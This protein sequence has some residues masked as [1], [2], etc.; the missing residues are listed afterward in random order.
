MIMIMMM[1]VTMMMIVIVIVMV[2]VM[3]IMMMI[4]TTIMITHYI[5]FIPH[6][7]H[8]YSIVLPARLRAH[9]SIDLD[10]LPHCQDHYSLLRSALHSAVRLLSVLLD[11][12]QGN[13]IQPLRRVLPSTLS[14][15]SIYYLP[16]VYFPP[17]LSMPYDEDDIV[18][19]FLYFYNYLDLSGV[20]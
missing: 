5:L 20:S 7:N 19:C 1:M 11:Y 2:M 12:Q 13:P 17:Q 3:M 16:I 8:R 18:L 6:Y 10:D 15:P 4:Q 9:W 14:G